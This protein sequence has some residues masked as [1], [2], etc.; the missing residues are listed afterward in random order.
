VKKIFPAIVLFAATGLLP[1]AAQDT[2][3]M[4]DGSSRNVKI[5]GVQG[6]AYLISLPSPVPGQR[7]GTTTMKRDGVSR[8]LFG[9]DPVLDAVAANVVPGSL[10]SARARWTSLQPFLAIPES[11]AGEAGCLLGEILLKLNDP[12]RHEEAMV[13]FREVEAGAWNVTDRQRATRGRLMAMIRQGRLE[14][15]SLEA[16]QIERTAEEPELVIETRL[17]LAEARLASLRQ[18]LAENPRWSEDPPV[19]SERSRL[20][21]EGVD[22]A[23]F[24]FLFHGTKRG[25]SARGLWL[26]H[27][28]YREA[29]DE[30]AARDV[31]TD[32]TAIY[33]ETPEAAKAAALPE[34]KS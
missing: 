24:P 25:P 10:A 23:L 7:A 9:P 8:I 28:I 16:E 21:H 31:A 4:T 20:I 5:L 29:G 30:Q 15:A 13:L 14:E 1:L 18:L 34:K 2:V 26:A 6:D 3:Q 22:F 12:A 19:R 27:E 17:L 33:S 32:L 11:R